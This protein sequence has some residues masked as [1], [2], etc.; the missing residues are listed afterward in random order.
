[1]TLSDLG[2]LGEF[3]GSIGVL[4]SIVYLAIQIREQNREGRAAAIDSLAHQWTSFMSGLSASEALCDVYLRGLEDFDALSRNEKMR[5]TTVLSQITQ[6]TESLHKHHR[7]GRL[8]QGMWEGYETRVLSVFS[9]PGAK[10][11]WG[12]R[13]YWFSPQIREYV[14]EIVE[15]TNEAT[16][17]ES[18]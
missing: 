18:F 12:L 11:W 2:N 1:M 7:L 17:Y 10:T 16:G 15:K 13:R 5:F 4:A 3:L 14:D 6:I 8:D 9:H